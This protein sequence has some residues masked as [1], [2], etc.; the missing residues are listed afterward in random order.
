MKRNP[1]S[2]LTA[3]LLA[4]LLLT[5]QL[6]PSVQAQRQRRRRRATRPAPAARQTTTPP[7]ANASGTPQARAVPT[8]GVEP[9]GAT[10]LRGRED[11]APLEA[12][13]SAD[14]YGVFAEV[15]K[16][17]Q[18]AQDGELK[19]ALAAL[20]L[21]G[22]MPKEFNDLF[23]F[24]LEN[25]E[26][27]AEAR[28]VLT[29]MPARSG[30]PTGL[31]ALQFPTVENAA[32][33]E[34]KYRKFINTQVKAYNAST[35]SEAARR[36]GP[37]KTSKPPELNV[38][39]RRVGNCL[40]LGSEPFK[41]KNLK[42]DGTSLLS[43][44]V[45]F[46]SMRSRFASESLFVYVDTGAIQRGWAA[47]MEKIKQ[48]SEAAQTTTQSQPG[49]EIVSPEM[50]T[51]ISVV[52]PA[53]PQTEIVTQEP[54]AN[55]SQTPT[56]EPTPAALDEESA[57]LPQEPV[58]PG[59][60][61]PE[62]ASAEASQATVMPLKPS[63]SDAAMAGLS[64]VL[65]GV[66]GGVPRIPES[67]AVAVAL[68]GGTLSVRAAVANT[69]DGAVNLIPFLPNIFNGPSITSDSAS[70]APA[71]GDIFFS[72]SL[73][74]PR[75]FSA[76][77]ATAGEQTATLQTSMAGETDAASTAF[78]S[79]PGDL[80]GEAIIESVEKLF[81]FKF[82]EDLLPSLG[83]ELAVS[84]PLKWMYGGRISEI[85]KAEKEKEKDAEAGLVAIVA[86]NDPEKM[87]KIL[88][89]VATAFG[90]AAPGAP[91][92]SERREGFDIQSLGNFSY[93]IINNHLA[94]GDNIKAVRHVVDSYSHRQTLDATNSFRDATAWQAR[95]RIAHVFVSDALMRTT[96]E[97]A[98]KM[99]SV[100]S[101]PVVLAL[102]SQLNMTP[103]PA[104]Y[105][106]TNEGDVL[107]HELRLP[108]GLVKTYAAGIMIGVKEAPVLSNEATA[109]Y[110]MRAIFDAEER[111]KGEKQKQ[112]FGTLEELIKEELVEK[113]IVQKQEY[114][115]E[116]TVVGDRFEA[117]ATPLNYGKTGRRS[118]F[119]DESGVVRAAD[120]KGQ[121]ATVEDPPVD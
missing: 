39:L 21:S 45:R 86:L 79:E 26:A 110:A 58:L 99:A 27:L 81:G 4:A 44:S 2:R 106:A 76:L 101:D 96:Q 61:D 6:V 100:S 108:L 48:E 60:V 62:V 75:I 109:R 95:Q 69:P 80:G 102:V 38:L 37:S 74:W 64:T 29:L 13:L 10:P 30:L 113:W 90:F 32:S 25:T 89:R 119:V 78:A 63:E 16:V 73:E 118:F 47:Q 19:T 104:S 87:R 22:E 65:R 5:L 3:L 93:V 66:W 12:L 115:I 98:K 1:P 120:H 11:E 51:E 84:V 57:L 116:L 14:S 42:G 35:V 50:S 46:Q 49:S 17:G 67:F 71:D 85:A 9:Q 103:E 23:G 33:F 52:A 40:V 107:L 68:E 59:D 94:I 92:Q 53:V 70:L 18:L 43:D 7:T 55:P 83:N 8:P 105:A 41:L 20:R 28:Y 111:F 36:G 72:T 34:P 91:V 114:K 121:P 112:R 117:T 56:A 97:D 82:K 77:M 88:P 15:R 31:S 24:I 54:P